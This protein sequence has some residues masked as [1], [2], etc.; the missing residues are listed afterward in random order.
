MSS[1]DF[2]MYTIVIGAILAFVY[3][4]WSYLKGLRSCPREMWFLFATKLIEY[5]AYAAINM[6]FILWLSKDCGLG[7][8][9]AGFF[10]SGWS[11]GLSIIAMIAGSLMDS[12]GYKKT[13]LLSSFFLIFSRCFMFWVTD[14]TAVMILGFI[15]LA[16]GFAVVGP[17]VSVGIKRFCTKEG[18]TL[19]FG[20]FYVLMNVAYAIGGW[21]F[22]FMRN[23]FAQKDEMGKIINENAGAVIPLLNI[24]LSTYQLIHF[25]GLAFTFV[26]II[27][28]FFLREGV[29]MTPEGVKITPPEDMGSHFFTII[30]N[31]L[32]KASAGTVNMIKSVITE[33][34]FW[35]FLFMLSL[36]LF[37][38]F[39]FFH[40][41]YT[42]PK[43]GIRV[44]GEGA[45]IGSIYGVLNPVLIVFLVPLV[46]ALTKKTSSYKMLLIGSVVSSASVFLACI[47]EAVL[48]PLTNT[49]L[50]ELIFIK[51]LGIAP[52]MA[53]LAANPPTPAYWPL[54]LFIS[55]FT[56]G[57]AIWSP[58]L[59]QF[60]AEIAPTG[61]E[62][63]YIAL[64]VLPFF[65]AKFVVG[66]MSGWLVKTYTPL[67]DKLDHAGNAILDSSGRVV[68]VVGDISNHHM[69]WWWVGGMAVF[70]PIGLLIFRG[71]FLRMKHDH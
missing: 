68:Q 29:E 40:F 1:A 66:P 28:I 22:D 17:V 37:V 61:K 3:I 47:P 52:D 9:T 13:L 43:Y 2:I 35:T 15:P 71:L 57:E 5:T 70:T 36:T 18:A 26:S 24:H 33:R 69:V 50:G 16:I 38:R 44:L 6:T 32:K 58:R 62:G 67:V 49:V 4:V 14:P 42:F 41:H 46:A 19:G 12:I 7:D 45:K 20:L 60:T 64:S 51:W 63:T 65:V 30:R 55:V 48:S 23:I 59:M 31:T 56:I 11:M 25:F 8:I 10:I 53:A 34:M 54:I 39:I 21:Y 27:F